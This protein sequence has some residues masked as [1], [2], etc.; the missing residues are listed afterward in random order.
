MP[1]STHR[2]IRRILGIALAVTAVGCSE[3]YSS[4]RLFWKAQQLTVPIM[5]H[6]N[7]A[8]PEQIAQSVEAF[9]RVIRRT[10]GTMW[11]ARAQLIIG[12]LHAMGKKYNKAREA[13]GLVLQNYNQYGDLCL[14]ARYSTAKTFEAEQKWEEALKVYR[15]IAEYHTWTPLGLEAPLY[16]ASV[17]EKRQ[18]AEQAKM[19]YERASRIYLR[20]IPEAPSPEMAIQV[21]GYL[22]IAYQR[23]GEWDKAI[24]LLE[25]LT[26]LPAGQQVNRPL[27]L[28]TL[29]SIYQA[30]LQN[31]TKAGDA[32]TKLLQEFPAHPFGKVAKAQLDALG[33]P[34]PTSAPAKSARPAQ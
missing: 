8:T 12:T 1:N 26:T 4:E 19:A 24:A 23:L 15:D 5:Q 32:Y 2:L 14:R 22:T 16:I 20:L 34:A 29:G 25:E 33:L 3:S 10:P 30:K 31:S 18:Q 6:P 11:A 21:K 17:Y 28:L 13:Y 7:S 27:I 9:T